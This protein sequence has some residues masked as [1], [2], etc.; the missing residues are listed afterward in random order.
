MTRLLRLLNAV[1]TLHARSSP[2]CLENVKS[3]VCCHIQNMLHHLLLSFSVE[4]N[5]PNFVSSF[6]TFR[7]H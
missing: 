4:N 3:K 6:S 2:V 1:K 7:S 5:R